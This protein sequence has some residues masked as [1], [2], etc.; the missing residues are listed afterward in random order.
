MYSTLILDIAGQIAA[1]TLNRPDKRNAMSAAMIAELQSALD[2]IERSH[3]RVGILTGAGKAFCAGMDLD[4]LACIAKQSPAEN[5]EDSRRIAK[6][7]RRI[8]SFPRPLIAAV[9]GAAY[10]RG[11]GVATLCGFT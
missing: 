7:F 4:M 8:W 3:A 1:I 9:K 2:E 6:L 11:C 10:A 5:Q